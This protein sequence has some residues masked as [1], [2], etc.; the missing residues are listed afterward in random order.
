MQV[1]K[2][3]SHFVVDTPQAYEDRM[4]VNEQNELVGPFCGMDGL[5]YKPSL[6]DTIYHNLLNVWTC[7]QETG[8]SVINTNQRT[9]VD[10]YL[11]QIGC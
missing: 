1:S 8:F 10:G 3:R 2:M 6:K 5:S 11:V 4:T 7:D 9:D